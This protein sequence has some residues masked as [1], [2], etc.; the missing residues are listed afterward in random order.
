MIQ[1][2]HFLSFLHLFWDCYYF[3]LRIEDGVGQSVGIV[4]VVLC[5]IS[6]FVSALTSAPQ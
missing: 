1:I 4:A 5:V 6:L 3:G 2:A